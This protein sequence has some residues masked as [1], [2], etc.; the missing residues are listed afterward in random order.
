MT[1]NVTLFIDWR[2][3]SLPTSVEVGNWDADFRRGRSQHPVRRFRPTLRRLKSAV[4]ADFRSS[5]L[6]NGVAEFALKL[7]FLFFCC[8]IL[9]SA[10]DANFSLSELGKVFYEFALK[11]LLFFRF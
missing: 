1:N 9:K 7:F 2:L 3:K 6:G 8:W 4:D 10:G 11:I 5:E